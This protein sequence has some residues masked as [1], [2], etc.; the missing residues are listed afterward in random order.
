MQVTDVIG[1]PFQKRHGH[2][3]DERLAHRRNVA[4]EKLVLQVT[5]PGRND[6]LAAPHQRRNQIGKGLACPR[7]RF[8]N[9][10]LAADNRPGNCL[11]HL[12]LHRPPVISID[13]FRKRA[14]R[15]HQANKIF[16]LY[17]EVVGINKMGRC[18][19]IQETLQ[20][21]SERPVCP[22]KRKQGGL[23]EKTAVI[24]PHHAHHF[25][26]QHGFKNINPSTDTFSYA[27]T[28]A[29]SFQWQHTCRKPS[30]CLIRRS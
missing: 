23:H 17:L 2:W 7:S 9:Q 13:D 8:H 25:I 19:Q 27:V 4:K 30:L 29:I 1:T 16:L 11:R 6:D 12:E 20:K 15:I 5:R 28:N 22:D 14:V 24:L 10:R 26:F 18:I 3:R 21:L